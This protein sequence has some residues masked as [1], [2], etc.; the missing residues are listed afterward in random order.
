MKAKKETAM[1]QLVTIGV[2][3]A[4]AMWAQDPQRI[5]MPFRDPSAPRKLNVDVMLGSVTIKGY[6]GRDAIIEYTANGVPFP[7]TRR[8]NTPPEA[9]PPG[10]HRI[11]GGRGF[12]VTEDNNVVQVKGNGFFG[13]GDV[14]IQVPYDTAVTAKTMTGRTVTVD[15]ISGEI[16]ANNM[17]GE[18]NVTNASGSVVAH[19]MNGKVIVS[20]NKVTPGKNMSFSTMNGNV[21]VTLPADTKA[22]LKMRADN[23]EIYTDFDVKLDAQSTPQVEEEKSKSGKVRRRVRQNGAEQGTINGGGAEMQFTTFNGRI[24]IHK[25]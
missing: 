25:K 21:D 8:N 22:N 19:S 3:F 9:P 1:R 24:L 4:G 5:T 13:S 11:G 18:V 17:N 14:T 20:L 16:E 15:N 6:E 2:V 7:G 10:M 12:E 23:G